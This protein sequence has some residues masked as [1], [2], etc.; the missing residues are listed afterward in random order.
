MKPGMLHNTYAA[1]AP[2]GTRSA[3]EELAD[4]PSG[5]MTNIADAPFTI[6]APSEIGAATTSV[7][8]AIARGLA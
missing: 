7:L 3:L 2:L 6:H 5:R 4:I 8:E 1:T